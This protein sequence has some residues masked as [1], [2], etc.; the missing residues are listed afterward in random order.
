MGDA[1][2]IKNKT[3][4]LL[5][6]FMISISTIQSAEQVD[7]KNY[8][9][10]STGIQSNQLDIMFPLWQSSSFVIIPSFSFVK[11]SGGQSDLGVGLMLRQNLK[12]EDVVPYIGIRGGMLR[13]TPSNSDAINDYVAGLSFGGEYFVKEKLSFGVEAQLNLSISDKLSTRFGNPD[14]TTVNTA[15]IAFISVYF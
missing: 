10:I 5:V 13:Y 7:R 3:L 1:M 15:S 2:S 4:L 12:S 6:I 9:G 14:G 8:T 11:I